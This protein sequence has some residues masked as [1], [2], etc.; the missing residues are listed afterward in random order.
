MYKKVPTDIDGIN[1]DYRP[2]HFNSFKAEK[3]HFYLIM[4]AIN[5]YVINAMLVI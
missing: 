1:A 2:I 5:V 4:S 3:Q